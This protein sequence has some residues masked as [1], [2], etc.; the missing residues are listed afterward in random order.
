MLFFFPFCSHFILKYVMI[1]FLDSISKV[2]FYDLEF[3][4]RVPHDFSANVCCLMF[5]YLYVRYM[6]FYILCMVE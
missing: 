2:L 1:T 4:Q 3:F 5:N 6:S